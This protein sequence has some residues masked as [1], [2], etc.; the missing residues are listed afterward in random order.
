[1]TEKFYFLQRITYLCILKERLLWRDIMSSV[2]KFAIIA[3]GEGSR[4]AAEGVNSPKPLVEICGEALV[5]RLLRIFCRCGASEFVVICNPDRP[6]VERHLR[7]NACL[8]VPFRA[9]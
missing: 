8:T 6:E 2:M 5:D 1:M 3:A 9:P 7:E 4:L